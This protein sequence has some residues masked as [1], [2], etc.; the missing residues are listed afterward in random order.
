MRCSHAH[1][2]IG[3]KLDGTLGL[4]DGERLQEHLNKCSDCRDLLKDF[5]GIVEQAK[6]LPKHE[7]SRR[8]W[9]GILDGVR[10]VRDNRVAGPA[11]S[12]IKLPKPKW[13]E[14]YIFASRARYAWA[15]ALLLVVVGG[16]VIGLRPG[17]DLS[18]L[19]DQ[20]RF[21]LAKLEE[22]EKHYKLAI[23]ALSEAVGSQ[24]NRFDPLVVAVFARNLYEID[25]AIQA[26]QAAV[27][28]NPNDLSAREYLLGVYKDKVNFLDSLIDIRKASPSPKAAGK[29]I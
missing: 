16:V 19:T 24:T 22:A 5:Q 27:T 1:K 25:T 7:P 10:A 14:A 26:C 18:G 8:V 3:D 28:K 4:K 17:K 11:P 21:T 23:Q 29:K 9:T 12:A 6:G 15:A 2:L 13:Y 20:D